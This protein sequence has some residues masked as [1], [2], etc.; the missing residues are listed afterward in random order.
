MTRWAT[1]APPQNWKVSVTGEPSWNDLTKSEVTL[2]ESPVYV[3]KA[4]SHCR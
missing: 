4:L 3:A 1:E 2:M